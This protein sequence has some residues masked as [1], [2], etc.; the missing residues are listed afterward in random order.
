M[1]KYISKGKKLLVVSDTGIFR[2]SNV[3]KAFGPVVLELKHLLKIFDEITWIG[4][5]RED[6][7]HNQSYIDATH[8][9]I[10]IKT[11]PS[12]GGT[13]LIAKIKIVAYYPF[14]FYMILKE[15]RKHSYIHTRA[16]SNPAVITMFLSYLFLNKKFWH[17]YAGS[18]VDKASFFYELQRTFLKKLSKNSFITINGNYEAENTQFFSFENPCLDNQDRINGKETLSSKQ[19]QGEINF[20]FVGALNTNKGV[21]K[22]LEAF[23][24]IDSTKIGT[25]HFVGDSKEKNN[26]IKLSESIGYKFIF[27]GFLPKDKIKEI[28]KQSHFILLPSKSEG[29]PKVI[30]EAM[31]Y[32]CIPVVSNVSCISQYIK[33]TENGYLIT[34]N[35]TKKLANI[36]ANILD[37]NTEEFHRIIHY[38]YELAEKFTYEYYNQKLVTH[39]FI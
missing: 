36:I 34:P 32:G 13:S 2:T 16:P 24:S 21:D 38:N 4:F 27:H 35:T 12:V 15:I 31:N 8:P 33:N 1:S 23:Q 28:Y 11:L 6:Q 3:Y 20:C 19:L 29:F 37:L 17:K 25:I 26:F 10:K 22:V 18:W 39:I 9:K 30:G 7:I 5:S 14:M